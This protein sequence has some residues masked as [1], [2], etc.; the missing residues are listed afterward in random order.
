MSR[1]RFL[2]TA[3]SLVLLAGSAVSLCGERILFVGN[4][5]TFKPK[6]FGIAR[7]E[8][9]NGRHNGGVPELFSALAR[10]AGHDPE[11][12]MLAE[13]AAT[14]AQHVAYWPKS[15]QRSWD[16]VILQ[17]QSVGP[18]VLNGDEEPRRTFRESVA[19]LQQRVT[20]E[21]PEV[22]IWMFET[23]AR[24]NMVMKGVVADLESMQAE[25]AASYRAVAHQFGL[26]GV[27]PVG[28]AFVATV[29]QGWA[30]NPATEVEEGPLAMWDEHAYHQSAAG[31]YLAALLFVGRIYDLDPREIP[32]DNRASRAVHLSDKE[33]AQLAEVAWQQLQQ[34]AGEA[35]TLATK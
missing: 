13:G 16:V 5:F 30:D 20:A 17:E 12:S 9:L 34:H 3:V 2:K 27:V 8:S 18:M 7:V 29:E 33:A 26:A 10:E 1:F 23:W 28:E 19:V 6:R 25:L 24:P 21:N 31:G 14:L 32:A 4:S 15:A 35:E 22:Q 11:V